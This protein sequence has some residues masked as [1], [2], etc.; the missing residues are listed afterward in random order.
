M[1]EYHEPVMLNEVIE[2]INPARGGVFIDGT[3]GGCGHS[4]EMLLKMPSDSLLIGIDRDEDAILN[5]RD[6]I[7]IDS[8]SGKRFLA[9]HGNFFNI[10]TIAAQL[11]VTGAD[12]I[13]LDLGVSSHQLDEPERGFSYMADAPL[14]MRMDKGASLLAYDV[15]NTYEKDELIR[16]FRDYGE[17][18]YSARI[19]ATIVQ[20]RE[21]EPIKSTCELVSLIKASM[22][23]KALREKQHPAK[24]V[25]QAIRIE[26][27]GELKGLSTAIADAESILNKDGILAVISFHSL[28]DR[29]VKRAFYAMEHPC[30]CDPKAPICTCGLEATSRVIT[31]KPVTPSEF[32]LERNPRAR[33]AK[34]RALRRI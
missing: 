11:G 20:R 10:K 5:A 24:R 2:L 26:V 29:I 9:V 23:V 13:L 19:A 15:V 3:L 17:E 22:P 6:V 4:S 8:A 1:S 27:N 32:E 21:K 18:R 16:I 34:L 12:G 7:R 31:K 14:D 30:V 25:F 33:S 28:E